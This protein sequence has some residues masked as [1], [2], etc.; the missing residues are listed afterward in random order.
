MKFE[1][2]NDEKFQKLDNEELS[3]ITGG[4][5][6]GPTGATAT[7]GTR[8]GVSKDAEG[9]ACDSGYK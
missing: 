2:L 9:G 5:C 6:D 4:G 8:G 7:V 3:K 1:K